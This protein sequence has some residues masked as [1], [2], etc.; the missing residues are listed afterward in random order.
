MESGGVAGC[1]R[2]FFRGE[3]AKQTEDA[4]YLE[5][6]GCKTRRG[7][8]LGIAADLAGASQ[9]ID[10]RADAA[11]PAMQLWLFDGGVLP[12]LRS[13]RSRRL[14]YAGVAA[15]VVVVLVFVLYP[16]GFPAKR[17]WQ[18]SIW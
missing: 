10:D 6:P 2:C 8:E 16:C 13:T 4:D 17:W 12:L 1:E 3:D 11:M 18:H 5:G 14:T 7:D 15:S 9:R